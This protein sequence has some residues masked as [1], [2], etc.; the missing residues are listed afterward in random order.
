MLSPKARVGKS[1]ICLATKITQVTEWIKQ[2]V[3]AGV[4]K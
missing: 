4:N 3:R 2:T 1:Q